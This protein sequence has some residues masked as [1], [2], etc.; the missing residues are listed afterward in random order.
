MTR[1]NLGRAAPFVAAAALALAGCSAETSVEAGETAET[2]VETETAIDPYADDPQAVAMEGGVDCGS[3]ATIFACTTT[4]GRALRICGV[5]A[6]DGS[7][8]AQYRFGPAS[9]APE[10]VLPQGEGSG[11]QWATAPYSGG[12][13]AQALF[14][15]GETRYVVYS[16][17]VRTGF[18]EGGNNPEF[19]DGVMVL[20]GGEIAAD[21][22]CSGEADPSLD[23]NALMNISESQPEL[24]AE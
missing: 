1:R 21:I 3:G 6:G 2:S 17:V 12:G 19:S 8:F 11:A 13:E 14:T 22:S 9:G 7:I 23:V 16:R 10:L 4:S 5:E 24:F 15:N 20:R 18:D